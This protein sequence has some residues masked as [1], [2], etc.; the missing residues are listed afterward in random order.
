MLEVSYAGRCVYQRP[1]RL[2]SMT[3]IAPWLSVDDPDLAATFYRTALGATEHHRF[4][5]GDGVVQVVGLAIGE[6]EFWL[7]R[8]PDAS[9][10]ALGGRCARMIVETPD[11][12]RLFER[13]LAAG[14]VEIA[15]MYDG[16][17]WHIGRLEA[18]DGHHWEI[19][20]RL[21]R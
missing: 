8:E 15:P 10:R 17:G 9:P 18:P 2:S 1:A 12:D 21:G 5:D 3:M 7:T 6:A 11:P 14:S 16:H 13:A 19:G 20:R 4:T